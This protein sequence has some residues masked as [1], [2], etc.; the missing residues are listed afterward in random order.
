M[1][2][3]ISQTVLSGESFK[4]HIIRYNPDKYKINGEKNTSPNH[5]AKLIEALEYTP[6]QQHT[7]SYVCYDEKDDRPIVT[8]TSDYPGFLKQILIV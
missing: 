3:I 8:T 6:T 4:I 2:R 7:L 5:V 1:L